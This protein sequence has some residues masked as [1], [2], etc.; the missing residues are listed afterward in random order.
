[1]KL[2][3]FEYVVP[4]S[5]QEACQFLSEHGTEAKILCG[6]TDVIVRMRDGYWKPKYVVD[7]KRISGLN[8]ISYD[9]TIGLTIG[10]TVTLNQVAGS[11]IVQKYYPVLAEGAHVIGSLQV[12]NRGTLVGNIC[13]ASPLADT[14]PALLVY[15]AEVTIAGPEG[16][17]V[18]PISEFFTG[19]GKTVLKIGEMVTKVTVPPITDA[20]GRYF[21]HARRKA[22]DLSSV[23]VAV[24]VLGKDGDKVKEVRIALG[25]VAPTPVRAKN[26]EA[27]L[28]DV[29]I[30]P[31]LLE[32]VKEAV[33]S[34]IS[35]ISDIRASKEYRTEI[36]QILVKRGIEEILGWE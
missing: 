30:T 22:V 20:V 23:G 6:G 7:I 4:G 36:S 15:E 11:E 33:V 12:R 31:E 29:T 1:M 27:L 3:N 13:N 32:K 5:V 25:A 8:K 35:P 2:T 17:R 16:E 26:A 21:K 14:A 18:V 28:K 34:D 19:P 24:L 10:A 9:E